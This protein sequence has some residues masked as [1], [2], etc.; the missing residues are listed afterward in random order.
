M[1]LENVIIIFS[2]FFTFLCAILDIIFKTF[3]AN[4]LHHRFFYFPLLYEINTYF[5]SGGESNKQ[6]RRPPPS[7]LQPLQKVFFFFFCTSLKIFFIAFL[8]ILLF[9]NF[10]RSKKETLF[11]LILLFPVCKLIQWS[12]I[13]MHAY[14][15]YI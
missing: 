2:S 8:S 11:C 14:V 12:Y 15:A 1:L 5:S 7:S 6:T 13:Y 9:P 3:L 4:I 10:F